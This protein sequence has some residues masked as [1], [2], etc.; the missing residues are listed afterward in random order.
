MI[1][2]E[3]DYAIR[4]ILYMSSMKE[5]MANVKVIAEPMGIPQSF[6]AKILQKLMKAGIVESIRGAGGGFR[7]QKKPSEINL[8]DVVVAIDG[9]MSLNRCVDDP[10]TCELSP[11]CVVHPIWVDVSGELELLIKS[12]DFENLASKY[13]GKN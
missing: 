1:T 11:D 5:K 8:Y 12:K 13:T 2:R 10:S 9:T 3:A 6:L 4:C 7:L